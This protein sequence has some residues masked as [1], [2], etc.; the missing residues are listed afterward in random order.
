MKT[1]SHICVKFIAMEII[2]N[3]KQLVNHLKNA[4]T[5]KRMAVACPHDSHSVEAIERAMKEGIADF[6]LFGDK[7]K[8]LSF[9]CFADKADL[10]IVDIKDNDEAAAAAV[11]AIKDKEADIL[12][13]GS[14]NTDNILRAILNKEHGILPK[15]NVLSHVTVVEIPGHDKLMFMTDVAVI[16]YPTLEQRVQMMKYLLATCR[17]FGIE[18]PKIGLVHF[19]EKV[20]Q[21]FQNSLDYV[22]L[23]NMC[24]AGE[25]GKAII[26]GPLDFRTVFDKEALDIKG[27]KSPIDG[28]GDGVMFPN[29]ESG[30][31]CYKALTYF[32]KAELAGLVMGAMCPVVVAS[33]GDSV[34]SK[35]YSIAMACLLG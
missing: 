25:F 15:G 5:K 3:F 12:M 23:K 20:N 29:I 21:K 33:R 26:D 17:S 4:D 16:P 10:K 7:D 32:A 24:E 9:P 19:T 31:I 27:I 22:E 35:F 13:K 2:R 28:D 6:I 11:K 14:I 34:D 18:C 8:I 30:N 1:F